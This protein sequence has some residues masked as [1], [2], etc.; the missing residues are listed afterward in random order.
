MHRRAGPSSSRPQGPSGSR[1]R[2]QG[3]AAATLQQRGVHTHAFS[4]GAAAATGDDRRASHQL[5]LLPPPASWLSP[6]PTPSSASLPSLPRHAA[7]RRGAPSR[8]PARALGGSQF[9]KLPPIP[10]SPDGNG[11]E[12]EEEE[13]EEDGEFLSR[14]PSSSA[15][16]SDLSAAARLRPKRVRFRA[17]ADDAASRDPPPPP[18]PI[19]GGFERRSALPSSGSSPSSSASSSSSS[20][21]SPSSSSPAAAASSSSSSSE[22]E[23]KEEEATFPSA[24]FVLVRPLLQPEISDA[25]SLLTDGF[26]AAMGYPAKYRRL[27]RNH[28]VSYLRAHTR[29]SPAAVVLGA[30]FVEEEEGRGGGGGV[31][32]EEG[33]EDE[34]MLGVSAAAAAAAAAA[35]AAFAAAS[36]PALS[37]DEED[38][39]LLPPPPPLLSALL[40]RSAAD[41]AEEAAAERPPRP[42]RENPL[43]GVLAGSVEVS[44]SGST[45]TKSLTLNPPDDA[46]Y[47]CNMAVHPRLRGKGIGAALLEAAADAARVAGAED[48]FL[49]LRLQDADG[50]AGRLYSKSG[51]E[52]A[53]RDGGLLAF[54]GQ[55]RRL[56]L[57]KRL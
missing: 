8:L 43:P 21:S 3:Q 35:V 10:G 23:E 12:D 36:S 42:P 20:S 7:L 16:S 27:L 17:F 57:R 9:D 19:F 56:L 13:E 53:G 41:G 44:F 51:F 55:E 38:A 30:R 34:E 26:A 50:P 18:C 40:A 28:I 6:S 52:E 33:G 31:G 24:P 2:C 4:G 48:V 5:P 25:A 49:H 32:E 54:F 45:R 29:L 47:L 37:E 14:L 15:A 39:Q 1:A 22:E 46:A 11:D